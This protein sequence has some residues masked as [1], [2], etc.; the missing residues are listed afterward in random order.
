MLVRRQAWPYLALGQSVA[1]ADLAAGADF[2]DQL[3]AALGT[4][5]TLR[6]ELGRG[7]MATVFLAEDTKHHRRVALKVLHRELAATLGP[8]RFRRE[9]ELA[10]R[11]Q[12]AHIVSV[13]DSG[14]AADGLLWFTM[15]YVEG[16]SLRDRLNREHQLP[17][18]DAVRIAS[19]AAQAL[20]YAHRRGVIHR[21]IKPENILI[22]DGQ[23]LV[24]DFGIARAL[25][26]AA[27]STAGATLTETGITLGTPAYMSP[28]QASGQRDLD[29]RTDVYS[30][31]SVLYEM[32]AGEPPFTGPNAQAIVAR[33]FTERPRPLRSVRDTVPEAVERT[34]DVA[35]AKA[36]ADRYQS[37][38]DFARAL[39]VAQRTASSLVATA[40]TTS[41]QRS[42]SVLPVPQRSGRR[43][44]VGLALLGLG[45]FIGVGV[46]FAWRSHSGA[47]SDSSGPVRLA[48]LPFDNVGDSADAYFADGLT[49]AVRDKLAAVPGLQVIASASSSQYRHT[50]KAPHE[51]GQELGV[52]YLLVGKVRWAKGNGAQSRVEVRPELVEVASSADK[53]GAPFDAPL[54]D[55]FQVQAD[56][57]EKVVHAL[58]VTLSPAA[59]QTVAKRPT[60]NLDA[61]DA[62]LRGK[63]IAEELEAPRVQRRAAAAFREAV[64]QDSTFALAWAALSE[65][66]ASMYVNGVPAPAIGDSARSSAERAIK[67]APTAAE[68]HAAMGSYFERVTADFDRAYSEY[69]AALARAPNDALLLVNTARAEEQSGRWEAAVPHFEQAVRLDPRAA[70]AIYRLGIAQLRFRRYAAARATLDRALALQPENLDYVEDRATVDLA[71]GDLAAARAVL[72]AVP[73]T[74]DPLA[75]VA[76]CAQYWDLGWVLDSAQ[77][78]LLLKTGPAAFDNDRAGWA[79]ILAEQYAWRGDMV[80]SRAYADTAH[81]AF[82]IQLKG[83]PQDAQRHVENGLALAYLGRKTDAMREGERGVALQPI[84]RDAYAGPYFQHQLVRIYMLVGEPEKA[85]DQLEPLLKVPY[86]LSPG[87]LRIDP[88]F[89]PLRGNPRF[90]RLLAQPASSA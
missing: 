71:Q 31:G 87:W 72:H 29:A 62:Y 18:D 65:A 60:E 32:L 67:L 14:E 44:P 80:R 52:R 3:Q 43:I 68:A 61:Y 66:Y 26:A 38:G 75:L 34:V 4:Q 55:V 76:E 89:A 79:I 7:G 42:A 86:Y 58:Q 8:E 20:D 19:E 63:K 77:E 74:V 54:T 24:A 48:V 25:T 41:P 37:A 30:L 56:I 9:I 6:R 1:E 59:A 23:A 5:Y 47:G 12:H 69:S 46:L 50:A 45:F 15:P 53:W 21:D 16:E 84:S 49:D 33:R 85:L 82:E 88:T 70:Q 35:L 17:V 11:L 10:A 51:I 39:Q 40:R 57:A 64:T 90:E 2:Q 22:A 13:Y 78:R 81:A 28:E 73:A 83:A 36:P 27:S